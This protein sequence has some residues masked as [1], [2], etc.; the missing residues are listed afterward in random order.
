MSGKGMF[1]SPISRPEFRVSTNCSHCHMWEYT[2]WKSTVSHQKITQIINNIEVK[3]TIQNMS[4]TPL[5]HY[6]ITVVLVFVG[7]VLYTCWW[8]VVGDIDHGSRFVCD[9]FL[10]PSM[11]SL[12]TAET[13]AIL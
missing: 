13:D 1:L 3:N 10:P 5:L 6:Y 4:S 12:L 9:L 7:C 11:T 8:T 2:F